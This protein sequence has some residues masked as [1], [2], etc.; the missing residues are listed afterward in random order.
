MQFRWFGW[1]TIAQERTWTNIL[2][3]E[4]PSHNRE[5]LRAK[6]LMFCSRQGETNLIFM[7]TTTHFRPIQ[8]LVKLKSA[9]L[10]LAVRQLKNGVE[11]T[12]VTSSRFNISGAVFSRPI[13][14]RVMVFRF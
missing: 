10:S 14:L 8:R 11:N 3:L 7:K 4:Y 5:W 6:R 1:Q 12:F 2:E 9:P 13:L